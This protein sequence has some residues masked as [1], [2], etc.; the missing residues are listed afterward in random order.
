MKN[1]W[2]APLSSYTIVT[3]KMMIPSFY[4]E[5]PDCVNGTMD[6]VQRGYETDAHWLW[7]DQIGL[8]GL[9]IIFLVIAYI[10]L[11]TIKKLK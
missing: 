2:L 6:L 4:S 11:R 10:N 3:V 9:T 7:Y 8:A 1:R 5:L